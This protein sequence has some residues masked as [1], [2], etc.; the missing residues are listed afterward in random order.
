MP[1]LEA[2]SLSLSRSP[3][4]SVHDYFLRRFDLSPLPIQE[5]QYEMEGED[6][7]SMETDVFESL[8]GVQRSPQVVF[9]AYDAPVTRMDNIR[10]ARVIT[11]WL[12]SNRMPRF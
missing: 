12:S 11:R 9:R 2:E 7:P 8:S 3:L 10:R 6:V 4:I 1:L 5:Y